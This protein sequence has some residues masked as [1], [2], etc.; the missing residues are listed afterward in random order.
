MDEFPA[1]QEELDQARFIQSQRE[2]AQ[3][4]DQ[5]ERL[6]PDTILLYSIGGIDAFSPPV[7]LFPIIDSRPAENENFD[8]SRGT[9]DRRRLPGFPESGLSG[10]GRFE[11]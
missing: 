1:A 10:D 7:G 6:E 2:A 3:E 5:D 8:P 11:A 9:M 4:E